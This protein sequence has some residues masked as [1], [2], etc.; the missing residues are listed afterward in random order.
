MTQIEALLGLLGMARL[1]WQA[2]F[3]AAAGATTHGALPAFGLKEV[4]TS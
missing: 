1:G 2:F 4:R 3:H